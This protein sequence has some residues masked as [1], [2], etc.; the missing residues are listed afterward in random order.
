MYKTRKEEA[1]KMATDPIGP[2]PK[3]ADIAELAAWT[4]V[5]NVVMNMD[6]FLMRR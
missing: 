4:A 1:V 6:E 5:A 3:E 2:A